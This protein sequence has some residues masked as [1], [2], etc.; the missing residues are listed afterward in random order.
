MHGRSSWGHPS[1]VSY[2]ESHEVGPPTP[3]QCGILNATS[4]KLQAYT[5]VLGSL[6]SSTSR[7]WAANSAELRWKGRRERRKQ[8]GKPRK[9]VNLQEV[10]HINHLESQQKDSLGQ[11]GLWSKPETEGGRMGMLLLWKQMQFETTLPFLSLFPWSLILIS[12]L[13]MIWVSTMFRPLFNVWISFFGSRAS[14]QHTLPS[15]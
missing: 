10:P 8:W 7:E 11:T 15:A 1:Q 6:G 2:T 12:L 3:A 14:S 13:G 4:F 9:K 5:E